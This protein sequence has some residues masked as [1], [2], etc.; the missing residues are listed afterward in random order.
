ME[1]NS[2]KISFGIAFLIIVLIAVLGV[3]II[4]GGIKRLKEDKANKENAILNP[5]IYNGNQ[6]INLVNQEKQKLN[7]EY[8]K[9]VSVVPTM[10]DPISKDSAWCATFQ[11]IWNDLK[12]EV[13]KKDIIF[14][15]QEKMADNLNKEEF[16]T[17][18]ISDEYYYKVYGLKTRE[19]KDKIEK[20][21]H[22][23]FNQKSD[24]LDDIDW[25]D[26]ALN[27][28]N[29]DITKYLFYCML[30]RKFEFLK[31]FDILDNGT[32]GSKYNNVQYFGIDNKTDSKVGEQIDVLFYNSQD[33]FAIKINTKTG[34]KVTLYKNPKGSN[35]K[36]I[37]EN[38]YNEAN[39]YKGSI[40]FN[41][42]MDTF[43]APKLY[44][45][46][47]REYKEL[48]NKPFKTIDNRIVEIIN[49]IQ[50]IKFS[51]DENGG[52]IK[53]ESLMEAEVAAAE[54]EEPEQPRNFIVDN[55]FA[56]FL[57]EKGKYTPY[58][59]GR[60]EDISKFQ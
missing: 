1:K 44:F 48:Q 20:G 55:T 60:I 5:D 4:M 32:F 23:K 46:Q 56:I 51:L 37:Y 19:L 58:F 22:E 41:S 28:A 9:D 43:K 21:I 35:F 54:I 57:T 50:S 12:N 38:M 59:A 25:S 45:N 3:L 15:P 24:I 16:T 2:T 52:E 47:K 26:E 27:G 33:D 31:K 18:M 17:N 8:N 30:Y 6:N 7:E 42:E 14:T 29:P 11:L 13:V 34:D 39:K 49:A 10:E 36:E 40:S 53:S